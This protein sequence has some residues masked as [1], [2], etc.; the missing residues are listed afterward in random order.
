[1]KKRKR[2]NYIDNNKLNEIMMK[3]H[4]EYKEAKKEGKVLPRVPE[5]VGECIILIA[6][7]MATRKNYAGYSFIEEMISDA[8]ENTIQYIHNFN[9]YYNTTKNNLAFSY[10]TKIV[11]FAFIRRISLEKKQQYIAAKYAENSMLNNM[12]VSSN[13]MLEQQE[14][15]ENLHDFIKNYEDKLTKQKIKNR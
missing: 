6:Q 10:I 11:N 3:Y 15:Y 14:L 7:N 13:S 9:P 4:N 12:L 5:Y 2:T 1:M 8:I